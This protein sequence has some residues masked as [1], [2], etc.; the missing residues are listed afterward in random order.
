MKEFYTNLLYLVLGMTI[1]A[2]FLG[3]TVIPTYVLISV[4]LIVVGIALYESFETA[5]KKAFE[6]QTTFLFANLSAALMLTYGWIRVTAVIYP[7][8]SGVPTTFAW[9]GSFLLMLCIVFVLSLL[10]RVL[11]Q[12]LKQ[13]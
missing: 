11:S 2:C 6:E 4:A 1:G 13:K 8:V 10:Y 12:Y 5:T 3:T 7:V 9:I